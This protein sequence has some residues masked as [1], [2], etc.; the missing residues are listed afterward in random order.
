LPE[1]LADQQSEVVH[2]RS[3]ARKLTREKLSRMSG[4]VGVLLTGSVARG[5]ARTGPLGFFVDL[6]VVH[7]DGQS[8]DLESV[9]GSSTDPDLPFH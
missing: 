3:V 4:V 6:L 8:I 1:V 7:E 9:F 5:D 2:Y